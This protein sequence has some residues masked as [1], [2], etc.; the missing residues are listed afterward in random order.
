MNVIILA[1]GKGTRMKSSLP[2]VLH[3]I[4]G[5]ALISHVIE[6]VIAL[7]PTK[8]Y[9]IVGTQKKEI[10]NEVSSFEKND[11]ITFVEQKSALGTGHAVKIAA[12][13][14]SQSQNTLILFGDVPLINVS[15]LKKLCKKES[16]PVFKLMTAIVSDPSG[17]GRIVRNENDLIERCVE[18][19]DS[20]SEEKKIN[21]INT[22]IMFISTEKIKSWVKKIN[23]DNSQKEYYLL[24]IIPFAKKDSIPIQPIVVEDSREILGVNTLAQ[25]SKMERIFQ[26][27]MAEKFADKGLEIADLN[28]FD[29]RGELVFENDVKI[30]VGCIFVGNVFIGKGTTIEP[31]CVIK[32]SSIANGSQ[33]KAFTN[34]ENSIVGTNTIIGPYSRLR[35]NSTVGD[36]CKIGNFV[37]TKNIDI[38]EYSKASHL[39]YLGDAKIGKRVNIG[40]GTITCN[41]DGN[42]KHQTIIEDDAFIGS[43]TELIAPVKVKK[44]ATVGAGTT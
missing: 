43:N 27:K 10:E 11:L 42:Y 25:K 14:L 8:I 40:A 20:N 2:K 38:K 37:E 3:Q 16:N 32:D 24:D 36:N 19:K 34:I 33:I 30:D 18:E 7:K 6:S 44:G 21:E 15:S 26:Y 5:K 31:Y 17:Y 29:V 28:R 22:G 23:N 1:A 35:L 12:P 4:G 9:L 41:Y 13:H 39:S